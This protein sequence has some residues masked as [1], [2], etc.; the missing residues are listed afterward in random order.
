MN[1]DRIGRLRRR[2]RRVR[3]NQFLRGYLGSVGMNRASFTVTE[4]TL[5]EIERT[6][7]HDLP[8]DYRGFLRHI[9]HGFGPGGGLF[10]PIRLRREAARAASDAVEDGRHSRGLWAIDHPDQIADADLAQCRAAV[11]DGGG[12]T[13]FPAC[14]GSRGG[15]RVAEVDG[16]CEVLIVAGAMRGTLWREAD[17]HYVPHLVRH[18]GGVVTTNLLGTRVTHDGGERVVG[19]RPAGFLDWIEAWADEWAAAVHPADDWPRRLWRAI[20]SG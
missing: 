5:R 18:V 9:G 11:L 10:D 17:G 7:D 1:D 13:A 2:F 3:G 16:G 4:A 19:D 8:R 20:T 12:L 14:R 15:L 6:L